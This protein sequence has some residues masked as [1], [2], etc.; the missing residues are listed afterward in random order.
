MR[1][2]IIAIIIMSLLA[3]TYINREKLDCHERTYVRHG[4]DYKITHCVV[5]DD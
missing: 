5:I 1:D 3:L 4:L 2:F